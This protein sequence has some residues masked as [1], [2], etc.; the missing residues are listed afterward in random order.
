MFLDDED[1]VG[2]RFKGKTRGNY[3]TPVL[4]VNAKLNRK[5]A[6]KNKRTRIVSSVTVLVIALMVLLGFG[7]RWVSGALF[8]NNGRYEIKHLVIR[9]GRAIKE[10][11]IREYTG[12]SEGTNLFAVDIS[13]VRQKVLDNVPNIRN[14]EIARILPD[15]MVINVSERMPMARVGF[16]GGYAIDSAGHVFVPMRRMQG[17]PFILGNEAR[18]LRPG[19]KARGQVAAALEVVEMCDRHDIS[20]DVSSIEADNE[21]YLIVRLASGKFARLNWEGMRENTKK[22]RNRL[23]AKLREWVRVLATPRGHRQTRFDLTLDDIRSKP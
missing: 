8:W 2:R 11:R 1:F 19:K 15:T 7:L 3:K 17:L 4:S 13:G 14:L 10:A 12:I 21:D 18:E 6:A 23:E 22:S 16:R 9:G 20:L 5:R